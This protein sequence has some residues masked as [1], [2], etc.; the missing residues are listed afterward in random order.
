MRATAVCGLITLVGLVGLPGQLFAETPIQAVQ[1]MLDRLQQAWQDPR[2][3]AESR[4]QQGWDL[5]LARVDVREMSRRILGSSWARPVAQQEA[6]LAAFTAFMHRTFAPKLAQLAE[7]R[8]RCRAEEIDGARAKV[9]AS[10]ETPDGEVPLTLHLHQ[11]ATEWKIY[12]VALGD[13]RFSLVSSYRAQLQ[14]LLHTASFEDVLRVIRD[15]N[16]R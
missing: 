5:L 6:F 1:A 2:L 13:G 4:A 10:V 12:D 16:A 14:G 3:G 11:Q 8:P 9:M 15:K 7:A